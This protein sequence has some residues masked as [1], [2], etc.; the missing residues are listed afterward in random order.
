MYVKDKEDPIEVHSPAGDRLAVAFRV[1]R[2]RYRILLA[3]FGDLASDV[4]QGPA[5]GLR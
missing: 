1:E 3:P 4:R 5:M 2:A